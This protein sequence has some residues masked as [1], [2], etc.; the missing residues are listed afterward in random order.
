MG[1]WEIDSIVGK[2]HQGAIISMVERNARFTKIIKANDRKAARV[3][4][5]L[6]K[7]LRQF[8]PK[9]QTIT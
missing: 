9:V 2:G 6:L 5:A 8:K 1:D 7:G 4:A 3:A